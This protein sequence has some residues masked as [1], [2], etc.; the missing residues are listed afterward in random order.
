MN[1]RNIVNQQLAKIRRIGN[2]VKTNNNHAH[3]LKGMQNVAKSI[4]HNI[5]VPSTPITCNGTSFQCHVIGTGTTPIQ[6]VNMRTTKEDYLATDMQEGGMLGTSF[7]NNT[8]QNCRQNSIC[9]PFT[10]QSLKD[11]I[12]FEN[13]Q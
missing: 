12:G 10:N 6:Q 9:T 3:N 5:N 8:I 2:F 13:F 1:I 7:A 4:S 11:T